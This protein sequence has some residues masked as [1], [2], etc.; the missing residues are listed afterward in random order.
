MKAAIVT[1]DDSSRTLALSFERDDTR[2][3]M[4][5]LAVVDEDGQEA[6]DDLLSPVGGELDAELGEATL[7]LPRA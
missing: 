6:F 1:A 5:T 4:R 2:V 7:W 3:A